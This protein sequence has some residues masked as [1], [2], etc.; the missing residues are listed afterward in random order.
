[1]IHPNKEIMQK[2]ISLAKEKNKEGALAIVALIVQGEKIISEGFATINKDN[3]PT[4]HAEINAI[5][6]A[7]KK[8]N[9][10]KLENCYLYSTFEP[11]PMCTSAAIWAKIKGIIYGANM[12]DETDKCPQRI[13]IQCK[14]ILEK[15][16]PQLELYENF[17]REECKELLKL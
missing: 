16:N 6:L 15:G 2:A 5:R 14:N 10:Y 8:L 9:S 4:S 3:D 17:M 7:T 11:C 12:N 13:K 1:M